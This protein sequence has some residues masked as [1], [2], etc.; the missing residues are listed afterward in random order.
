VQYTTRYT[1]SYT[2]QAESDELADC[3]ANR[4]AMDSPSLELAVRND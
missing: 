3:G 4:V 1:V 2:G